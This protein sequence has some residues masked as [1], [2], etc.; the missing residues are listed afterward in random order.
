MTTALQAYVTNQL[1]EWEASPEQLRLARFLIANLDEHGR[2]TISSEE[3]ASRYDR[4]VSVEELEEA[5]RLVQK[6]GPAGVGARDLRECLLLQ[7]TEE[8]PHREL[9]RK[10]I[11]NHL[12]DVE[13]R[14][15]S[16]IQQA[17]GNDLE[18]I[19]EAIAVL[20]GFTPRPGLRLP[21]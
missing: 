16:E 18:T 20:R 17:T 11:L 1:Q 3:L 4:P 21:K 15:L 8:T 14:R 9:V 6:L 13:E 7:L 12:I 19:N 5:L 2:L 10:I